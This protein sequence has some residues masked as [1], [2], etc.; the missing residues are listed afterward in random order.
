MELLIAIPALNEEASLAEIIER[1]L[2]AGEAIVASGV[3]DVVRVTVV[4]DGSTDGTGAIARSYE[5][6]IRVIEFA[7]NRGYGAAIK[8]AWSDGDAELLGVLDADGTCDPA[9]FGPLCRAIAEGADVALGCRCNPQSHMPLVRRIGNRG[10]AWLLGILANRTV[11]DTA[12]GMRVI[13]RACLPD[14]LP[15]PD[16][17]DFTP[18]MS[19]RALLS[20]KV[21]IVELDMPYEERQGHSKLHVLR[22]GARFLRTIA[23]AAFLLRPA[24]PL[25]LAAFTCLVAG[26]TL[27][28][29]PSVH[30]VL[31]REVQEWMIYRFVVAELLG[32]SWAVLLCGAYLAQRIVAVAVPG[33][34][35]APSRVRLVATAMRPRIFW[36][37]V[38]TLTCAGSW[39]VVPAALQLVRSGS[40]FEHWSRF[41][42]ASF[43][44]ATAVI[45]VTTRLLDVVL[46]LLGSHRAYLE[47]N[48]RH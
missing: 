10:F 24:R 28:V 23:R 35:P 33:L 13:R 5:G 25:S 42:A 6:R 1:T 38:A 31:H 30:Y 4:N 37:L 19:A 39:L 17:L 27:M 20:E 47:S 43:L 2:A 15:L 12:S 7:T 8:C 41:I 46:T 16:G 48:E 34:A 21:R 14:L 18:A 44:A 36:P 45:L 9:F 32:V 22:D 29:T 3:V 40:I 26:A 11:R